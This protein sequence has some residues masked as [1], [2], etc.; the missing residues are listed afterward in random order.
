MK[1]ECSLEEFIPTLSQ[2]PLFQGLAASEQSELTEDLEIVS[3]PAGSFLMEAGRK[4]SHTYF[5]L[6]GTVKICSGNPSGSHALLGIAGVGEVLGEV[7]GEVHAV[8]GL[9]HSASVIALEPCLCARMDNVRFCEIIKSVPQLS[10][11]LVLLL[12]RRLRLATTRIHSLT[13]GDTKCRLARLLLGF[14]SQYSHAHQH[15]HQDERSRSERKGHLAPIEIPLRLK[16][17]DLANMI[18]TTRPHLNQL[19]GLFKRDGIFSVSKEQRITI[20]MPQELERYCV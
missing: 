7:L 14:A 15:M 13:T 8:D 12:A 2:I 6:Q 10:N 16:Q 17:E 3:F 9:G 1:K 18:G 11:N 5:I 19:L 4:R 20:H